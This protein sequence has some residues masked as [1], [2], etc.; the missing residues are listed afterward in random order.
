MYFGFTE[1]ESFTDPTILNKYRHYNV[2]VEKRGDGKG[3]WHI[4]ILDIDDEHISQTIMD[5]SSALKSDWNAIFFNDTSVYC[6]FK[7]KV[8]TLN[9]KENWNLSDYEEV[10]EYAKKCDVGDLDMNEVF[11]HYK[12]LLGKNFI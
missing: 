8:F 12:H 10:K 1:S 11:N 2:V 9:K 7:D 5:I 3:Y 4:F 6:L